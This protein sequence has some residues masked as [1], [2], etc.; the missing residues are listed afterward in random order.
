MATLFAA[1]L[2][3]S[4]SSDSSSRR[5]DLIVIIDDPDVFCSG[6][7]GTRRYTN[8]NKIIMCANGVVGATLVTSG[9]QD[10]GNANCATWAI[11]P[12]PCVVA[13]KCSWKEGVEVLYA[14][15]PSCLGTTPIYIEFPGSGGRNPITNSYG[16]KWLTSEVSCSTTNAAEGPESCFTVYDS[17]AGG[18]VMAQVCI[19]V[20]CTQ[21]KS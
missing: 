1:G 19:V 6:C 11:K 20:D 5:A 10:I 16:P 4:V 3:A 18:A 14:Q 9:S 21:C 17:A 2:P 13:G 8:L 15:A 7:A 12:W